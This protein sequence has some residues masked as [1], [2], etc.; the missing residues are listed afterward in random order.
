MLTPKFMQA[1]KQQVKW[2]LK[3]ESHERAM[4]LLVGGSFDAIGR[5]EAQLLLQLG[6]CDSH[7]IV[8]V[9]CGSGR[10]AVQLKESH[11]GE[12]LGTDVLPQLLSHA[13]KLCG[14]ADWQ[15]R[16][17]S[18]TTIPAA[19]ECADFVVFFSVLTHLQHEHGF[20]YLAEAKRV[21]KPG[22]MVV[23]SFLEYAVDA[24][25]TQF[26]TMLN[27]TNPK[28][29]ENVFLGRDAP[30]V[31]ARHLQFELCAQHGGDE[32]FIRLDRPV[33]MDDGSVVSG[34]ASLGQ[35]VCVLRKRA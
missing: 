16:Q 22:G 25:W 29:V 21:L 3:H 31:W 5:I 4:E 14:R 28:K 2:W 11:Q 27:D 17:V 30:A 24:H 33:T 26:Q 9:G 8:D 20:R 18:G 35:S 12:Y 23:F 7:F 19:D 15:F 34:M 13:K 1:Y 10:L 6:L 32:A